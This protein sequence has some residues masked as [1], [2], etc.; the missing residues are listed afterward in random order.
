MVE[1]EPR[2]V[3]AER[4]H[5]LLSSSQSHKQHSITQL[6]IPYL[7][8]LHSRRGGG[9]LGRRRLFVLLRKQTVLIKHRLCADL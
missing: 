2:D 6:F 3:S 5:P 1:Q 4:E 7:A 8:L 9:A